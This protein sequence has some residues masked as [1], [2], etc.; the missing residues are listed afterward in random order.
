[1]RK[2]TLSCMLAAMMAVSMLPATVLADEVATDSS[3]ETAVETEEEEETPS[4]D[5]NAESESKDDGEEGKEAGKEEGNDGKDDGEEK[6]TVSVKVT[7]RAQSGN[8]YLKGFADQSEV[9]SDTA[10]SYGYTDGIDQTKGVSALDAMVEATKEIFGDDFTKETAEKYLKVNEFG[11]VTILFGEDTSANGFL[12]NGGYVNDGMESPW[13]GYNGLTVTTT[14]LSN[15]D[16]VDF[17]VYG[18]QTSWSD[19]Y[20][21]VE[22]EDDMLNGAKYTVTVKGT[23][24]MDGYLYKD[25]TEFKAA[26]TPVAGVRLAWVN[27]AT[28]DVTPIEGAVTD[29]NGQAKIKMDSESS[30]A[31]LTAVSSDSSF[32]LLNPTEIELTNKAQ[33]VI[34]GNNRWATAAKVAAK[35]YP[36]GADTAVLVTGTDFPDALAANAFAGALTQVDEGD[37]APILL[38]R[39]TDLPDEIKTLLTDTWKGSVKKVYIVGGGFSDQVIKDL[40]DCGVEFINKTLTRGNNRYETAEL[41]VKKCLAQKLAT[42]DT[43]ILTK[44]NTPADALSVSSWSFA[45]HIP[46]L[47]VKSDGTMTDETRKLVSKFENVIVLGKCTAKSEVTKCGIDTSNII[48]LNGDN[49]YQTSVKINEY[50]LNKYGTS[51]T[52]TFSLAAG[53]DKNFPDALVVGIAGSYA[54]VLLVN[55][56]Y[57]AP[58]EFVKDQIESRNLDGVFL[59]GAVARDGIT[60]KITEVTGIKS[61]VPLE[62]FL[63]TSVEIP[64]T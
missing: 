44:G 39:R 42:T 64:L 49:R 1:M 19:S 21:Y 28:G 12:V 47:L 52:F 24:V 18:D 33:V 2:K 30:K 50:F 26:A 48:E 53:E 6:E 22:V 43:V 25:G 29:E 56:N 37:G 40:E 36:Y 38:S 41:I 32:V 9:S 62:D 54:P 61:I 15:D 58:F 16:V 20:S 63:D 10:E 23:S 5:A 35:Y 8:I 45:K 14:E 55:E 46:V 57:K 17:F 51:D 27:P 59:I 34:K 13:G 3:T 7:I 31:Y 60:K 4:E 11:Y